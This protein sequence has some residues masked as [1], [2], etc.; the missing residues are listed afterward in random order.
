MQICGSE[1]DCRSIL[2]S[3]MELWRRWQ[4]SVKGG[5]VGQRIS[6]RSQRLAIAKSCTVILPYY[7]T[8][9]DATGLVDEKHFLPVL[10]VVGRGSPA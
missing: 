4:D 2:D 5:G 8:D 3:Y 6:M 9:L 7:L 1:R 10:E